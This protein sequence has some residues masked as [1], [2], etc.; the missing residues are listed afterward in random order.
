M[1]K[2]YVIKSLSKNYLYVGMTN[3]LSR[4]LKEHNRGKGR[5][6]KV[7]APFELVLYE[8]Y[9]NRVSARSREKYLK[10]GC[11]KEYIKNYIIENS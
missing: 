2:V 4:R 8:E 6:T 1:Y 5:A 7:Y 3:D 11:G 9:D 10:S